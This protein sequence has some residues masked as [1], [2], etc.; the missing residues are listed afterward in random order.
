MDTK[1]PFRLT[2]QVML[3]IIIVIVGLLVTLDNLGVLYARDYVRYWP[4]LI[5]AYG[6]AHLVQPRGSYGRF[7]GVV[8][9]L[10]GS[11]L[12]IDSL[13]F[14]NLRLADL[15]PLL[16]VLFGLFV[17]MRSWAPRT[18]HAPVSNLD[19]LAASDDVVSM[20][21][22]ASGVRRTIVSQDFKG[23]DLTAI[24]GG[25]ELDLRQAS[26][27]TGTAVVSV[28]ALW[29]GVD[30]KVPQDWTVI[31]KGL[32]ILGGFDDK[33]EQKPGA[34]T[35]QLVIRGLAIMGGASIKN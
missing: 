6:V 17:I 18:L 4:V 21:A 11:A 33:T 14:L 22:V 8:W 12:L 10:I 5:M 34:T 19:R 35:K 27:S 20:F 29:G 16:L 15:W 28:F 1:Q 30:L 24:M 25:C 23:G 26:I 9:L 13:A 3:G 32:P 2:P 7:G 31:V